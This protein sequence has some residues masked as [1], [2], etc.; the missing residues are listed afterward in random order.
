MHF[1]VLF[2]YFLTGLSKITPLYIT[3]EGICRYTTGKIYLI[4]G[5]EGRGFQNIGIFYLLLIVLLKSKLFRLLLLSKALVRS[6]KPSKYILLR[7]WMYHYFKKT[8][9][10]IINII[11]FR[12]L[13]LVFTKKW[14]FWDSDIKN[15]TPKYLLL[16][17]AIFPVEFR[18]FKSIFRGVVFEQFF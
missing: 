10:L 14:Y 12:G 6:N 3:I 1:L 7:Q 8:T 13:G 16:D 15:H 5:I 11:D 17:R 18:L 2:K 9:P 4:I